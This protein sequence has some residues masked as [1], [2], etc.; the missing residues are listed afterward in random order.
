MV[1]VGCWLIY[2]I[3]IVLVYDSVIRLNISGEV[4]VRLG[5]IVMIVFV[6]VMFSKFLVCCVVFSKFDVVLV[7]LFGVV[8]RM[9]DVMGVIVS[10]VLFL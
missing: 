1:V 4:C 9:V 8:D 5:I 6:V 10:V 3:V 7:S 2:V